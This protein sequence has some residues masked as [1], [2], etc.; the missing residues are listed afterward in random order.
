MRRHLLGPGT[1]TSTDLVG[2]SRHLKKSQNHGHVSFLSGSSCV[3]H[4]QKWCYHM[5]PFS[6]YVQVLLAIIAEYSG[7]K[8]SAVKGPVG[9]LEAYFRCCGCWVGGVLDHLVKD[10]HCYIYSYTLVHFL[11]HSIVIW[12]LGKN[13][14][15]IASHYDTPFLQV[16]LC[17]CV[18]V[19]WSL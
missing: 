18:L 5:C 3:Q 9:F 12:Y 6:S 17:V 15:T 19:P 4:E 7:S 2:E 13:L 1:Q 16:F 11:Q 14:C 8:V 10:I